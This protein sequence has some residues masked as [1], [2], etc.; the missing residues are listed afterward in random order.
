MDISTKKYVIFNLAT[1]TYT[2][3]DTASEDVAFN[4]ISVGGEEGAVLSATVEGHFDANS[5]KITNLGSPL[6]DADAATKSYVDGVAGGQ[7]ITGSRA[8]P[9]AITASGGI[10][11]ADVIAETIFL[12]GSAGAVDITAEPQISAAT[13][14]GSKLI[15]IGC[16]DTNTVKLDHGTGLDLN[17]SITLKLSAVLGLMWD[18]TAWLELFRTER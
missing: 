4:S 2:R 17:G 13:L 6:N 9:I 11:A 15:L 14:I 18:G 7:T 3:S 10:T 16:S 8:S 5:N 12:Q 1:Q